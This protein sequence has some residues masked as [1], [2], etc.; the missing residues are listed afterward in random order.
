MANKTRVNLYLPSMRPVKEKL[1]LSLMIGCWVGSLVLV[2]LVFLY[3]HLEYTELT[4]TL[5]QSTLELDVSKVELTQLE[6]RHADY[7]P[8]PQLMTKLDRLSQEL[9]GKRFLSQHLK[10]N[11]IPQEK[12]YSQVMLDLGRL[13]SNELWVTKMRFDEEGVFLKGFALDALAVPKWLN[14]L[15]QSPFFSGKS[16]ALMN[17]KIEK[18]DLISFEINTV[19]KQ[20]LSEEEKLAAIKALASDQ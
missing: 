15:Q 4:E 6:T 18:Q 2:S 5:K 17:L 10:G 3:Q 1:P 12:K 7:K 20:E 13:H 19:A 14:G 16:F 11:A 9:N 8:S